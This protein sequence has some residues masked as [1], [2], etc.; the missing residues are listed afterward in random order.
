MAVKRQEAMV[1]TLVPPVPWLPSKMY[2]KEY[3]GAFSIIVQMI[4]SNRLKIQFGPD[5]GKRRE[6]GGGRREGGRKEGARRA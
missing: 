1:F 5:G 3:L 6:E 4:L 2:P